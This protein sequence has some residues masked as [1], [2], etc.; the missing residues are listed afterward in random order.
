[1]GA[2]LLY[3]ALAYVSLC[4]VWTGPSPECFTSLLF[5][6]GSLEGVHFAVLFLRVA[7]CFSMGLLM[8]GSSY[9]Y[10]ILTP[11]TL[12]KAVAPIRRP[13]KETFGDLRE[14]L[15]MSSKILQRSL[16]IARYSTL[17][18]FRGGRWISLRG[19]WTI[20]FWGLYW[21]PVILGNYHKP[22][23]KV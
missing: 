23:Q 4:S 1:M 7:S 21:G 5:R 13:Y 15:G 11:Y 3:K 9:L 22:R 17:I 12:I 8:N 18:S 10:L 6:I 20:V 19:I 16:T 2:L 14:D